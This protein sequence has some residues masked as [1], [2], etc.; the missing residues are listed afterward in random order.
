MF[1]SVA[2]GADGA[3]M[4]VTRCAM[5]K[6]FTTSAVLLIG[7]G[8]GDVG[9]LLHVMQRAVTGRD[10]LGKGTAK[11]GVSE[12]EGLATATVGSRGE[13]IFAWVTEEE[14]GEGRKVKDGL[15]PSLVPV[16]GKAGDKGMKDGDVD[17]PHPEGGGV[18]ISPGLEEGLESEGVMDA[19]QA[20]IQEAQ[21]GELLAHGM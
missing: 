9:P 1:N 7:V 14:E 4:D 15:S 13:G 20:G 3:E 2:E 18:F 5:S 19:I 12:L 17:R 10:A 21:L 8:E 11:S 6:G 16:L